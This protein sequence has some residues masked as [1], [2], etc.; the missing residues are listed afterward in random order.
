VQQYTN[1]QNKRHCK[2][3]LIISKENAWQNGNNASPSTRNAFKT[4]GSL[5]LADKSC[6]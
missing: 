6:S 1:D 4:N 3:V 5:W 2:A